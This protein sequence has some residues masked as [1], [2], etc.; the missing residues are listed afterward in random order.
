MQGLLPV[1]LTLLVGSHIAQY[2]S[3]KKKCWWTVRPYAI[4]WHII[5]R[6]RNYCWCLQYSGIIEHDTFILQIFGLGVLAIGIWIKVDKEIAN[7]GEVINLGL[8]SGGDGSI[9]NIVDI[10]AWCFIAAGIFAFIVGFFGCCGAIRESRVLLGFV[11]TWTPTCSGN[12]HTKI[13][14][15]L[16]Q[17]L[18][19]VIALVISL[20]ES[21]A[22]WSPQIKFIALMVWWVYYLS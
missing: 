19:L 11:S 9:E 1:T 16:E 5:T 2:G 21:G 8:S 10:T 12:I 22:T 14:I 15:T 4:G 17:R 6:N 13:K 3:Y 20:V 18:W 7:V